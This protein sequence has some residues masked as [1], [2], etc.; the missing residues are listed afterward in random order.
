MPR[1]RDGPAPQ[2][3]TPGPGKDERALSLPRPEFPR[4]T[5]ARTASS[6]S[7]RQARQRRQ[8]DPAWRGW[9]VHV[10]A[11]P[12]SDGAH[13]FYLLLRL[14]AQKYGLEVGDVVEIRDLHAGHE[15]NSQ[16]DENR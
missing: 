12:T 9:S 16:S 7:H 1:S 10:Y 3:T 4:N 2:G 14:A 13:A 5:L 6:H 8:P 11:P 15:Q